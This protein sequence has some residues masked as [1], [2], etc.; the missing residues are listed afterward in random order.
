MRRLARSA[1]P[2]ALACRKVANAPATRASR[3]STSEVATDGSGVLRLGQQGLQYLAELPGRAGSGG[4]RIWAGAGQCR[5]EGL[6]GQALAEHER[7]HVLQRGSG[8]S[9]SGVLPS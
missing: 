9:G 6:A 5:L 4:A 7:D 8:I 1:S 3:S 2:S